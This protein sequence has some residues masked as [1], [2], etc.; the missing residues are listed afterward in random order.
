MKTCPNCETQ[1]SE[2]AVFCSNCGTAVGTPSGGAYT[3][4]APM[5]DPYDHTSEFE[6]DDISNNK[7]IAMLVYIMSFVGIIIALLAAPGS[8]YVSFHLRQALKFLVVETLIGII[9]AVTFWTILVPVAAAFV[10]VV[11]LVAKV[12]CF[13]DV[14]GGKAKEPIIIRSLGFLK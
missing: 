14:C 8:K 11:L 7:V 3:P 9:V 5:Y 1:L 10:G 6:A 4:P 2:N 12:V 13:F